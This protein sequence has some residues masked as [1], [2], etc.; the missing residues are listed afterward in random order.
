[1]NALTKN[2]R[3]TLN[4]AMEI[5]SLHTVTGA[6]FALYPANYSGKYGV[7]A[8]YFTSNKTQHSFLR[9]A[10]FADKVDAALAFERAEAR[11]A[12]GAKA[13]RVARLKDELEKLT[14]DQVAA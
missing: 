7:D 1:M 13:R 9:G 14:A 11:D 12:E 5:L 4:A 2:E 3:E 8:T 10:T 6:S